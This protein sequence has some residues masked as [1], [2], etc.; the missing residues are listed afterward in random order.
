MLKILKKEAV[1]HGAYEQ[2]YIVLSED[3]SQT[4]HYLSD[5]PG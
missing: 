5:Q 4:K 3:K 2:N 1:W